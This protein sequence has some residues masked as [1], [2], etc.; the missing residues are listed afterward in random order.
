MTK[1]DMSA[2]LHRAIAIAI[3]DCDIARPDSSHYR[4]AS[5]VMPIVDPLLAHIDTLTARVA[6]L[7]DALRPFAAHADS[8]QE[9]VPNDIRLKNVAWG[10]ITVGDFRRARTILNATGIDVAVRVPSPTREDG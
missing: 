5:A 9:M 6:A 10:P 4:L 3:H 8:V 2:T 1:D 7:E